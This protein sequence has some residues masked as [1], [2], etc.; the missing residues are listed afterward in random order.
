MLYKVDIT[1]FGTN[2]ALNLEYVLNDSPVLFTVPSGKIFLYEL[3]NTYRQN[4]TTFETEKKDC[5]YAFQGRIQDFPYEEGG[6]TT[7]E[8]AN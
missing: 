4:G 3:N 8:W 6:C 2:I 5:G 1:K 7:K